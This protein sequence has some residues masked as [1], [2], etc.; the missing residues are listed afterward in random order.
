[1]TEQADILLDRKQLKQRL[2][3]WQ[4]IALLLT[5]IACLLVGSQFNP[6]EKDKVKVGETSHDYIARI[7]VDGMI[8]D[9][10]YRDKVLKKLIDDKH[11]K[12]V[13]LSI[14]SPGG[15]TAGSEELYEEFR[16]ISKS[17]KPV[18]VVM[19]TLAASG[20]YMTA[21]AGDRIYARKGTI[22]GSIGVLMQ[23]AEFTQL[24]EKV[25]VR[26]D[27]IKSSELKAS[28]S[29]FE[30]MTPKAKAAIQSLID[31]FYA[32]F[33]DVVAERRHLTHDRAKELAD[34]RVY[35]GNQAAQNGL[36]DEIGGEKEAIQWLNKVK[37][38]DS[39]L[40]VEDIST[41]EPEKSLKDV[42]LGDT[43]EKSMIDQITTS[44]LLAIYH[45]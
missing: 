36:I 24:A 22:T 25:G 23:S 1:M 41:T 4:V 26:F 8:L 5:I 33:V 16:D 18:V 9:D 40:E 15:T 17:G 3:K 6:G 12:A 30:V 42:L 35:S 10:T 11:A 19:R 32:Y 43:K 44:G 29:P 31:D 28:P 37:K 13:I 45:P 20:G 2:R 14:D 7:K 27:T 39:K 34:G 38:V 21:L